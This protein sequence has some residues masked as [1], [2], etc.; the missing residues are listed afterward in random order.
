MLKENRAARRLRD[1]V[2]TAPDLNHLAQAHG[3]LARTALALGDSAEAQLHL[4]RALEIVDRA[5]TYRLR[6]VE[7]V[8][9]LAQNFEPEDR[10]H[11]SLLA[12]LA[13]RTAQLEAMT[14]LPSRPA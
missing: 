5:A 12:G 14:S 10:L 8:R 4:S 11:K 7:T 1:Y 6:F 2:A 3:L 13:T 9:R